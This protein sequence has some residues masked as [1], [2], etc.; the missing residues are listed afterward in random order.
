MLR[1]KIVHAQ[2]GPSRD[3]LDIVT[4]AIIAVGGVQAGHRQQMVDDMLR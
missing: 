3:R 1:N 4:D 2:G